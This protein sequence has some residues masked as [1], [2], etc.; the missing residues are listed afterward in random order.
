MSSSR[1]SG[2]VSQS[3]GIGTRRLRTGSPELEL[4]HSKVSQPWSKPLRRRLPAIG[5]VLHTRHETPVESVNS[6]YAMPGTRAN[7][8]PHA[9]GTANHL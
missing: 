8:I 2:A 5:I 1:S 9:P 4:V 7:L 3:R 6:R